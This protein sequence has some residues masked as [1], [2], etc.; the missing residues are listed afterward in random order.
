MKVNSKWSEEDRQKAFSMA[1][2][3]STYEE[4]AK[5]LGRPRNSVAGLFFRHR[6]KSSEK[7]MKR[8]TNQEVARACEMWREG[9]SY[10]AISNELG[11]SVKAIYKITQTNRE[12]FPERKAGGEKYRNIYNPCIPTPENT[13][14]KYEFT[15]VE[16][17]KD[18]K[19]IAFQDVKP[20]EC[21][22][23]FGGFWDE[24]KPTTLCCGKPVMNLRV[25]GQQRVYCEY[26][27]KWSIESE[28][29]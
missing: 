6:G 26:H 25:R 10:A 15:E 2:A 9:Q 19:R 24:P 8:W 17:P 20:G 21:T 11:R 3:G 16:E 18:A 7:K 23:I 12:L 29:S 13:K 22:W 27:Y 5:S 28:R 4:I 1:E 14:I